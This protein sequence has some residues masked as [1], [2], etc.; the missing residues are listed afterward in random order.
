M[1]KLPVLACQDSKDR[2]PKAAR[3][4]R[5]SKNAL[6]G[7]LSGAERQRL[8]LPADSPRVRPTLPSLKFM[9][10]EAAE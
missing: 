9:R 3:R 6:Q 1:D 2:T 4:R 7:L 10:R 8:A 5:I